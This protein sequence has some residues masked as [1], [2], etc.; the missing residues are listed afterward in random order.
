MSNTAVYSTSTRPSVFS[1]SKLRWSRDIVAGSSFRHLKCT[2]THTQT[3]TG[4]D[5]T[6]HE[7]QI[8][9]SCTQK[10]RC[11]CCKKNMWQ[12]LFKHNLS[13][14]S[15]FIIATSQ[16]RWKYKNECPYFDSNSKSHHLTTNDNYNTICEEK[17]F[18]FLNLGLLQTTMTLLFSC[19]KIQD[20]NTFATTSFNADCETQHRA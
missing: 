3:H 2:H 19:V 12:L 16:Q 1:G 6:G 5:R 17:C 4:Q 9:M 13:G 15:V 8:W 18:P 20:V 10:P 11:I 7:H 14:F